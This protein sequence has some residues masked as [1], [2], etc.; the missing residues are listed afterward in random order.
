MRL[1]ARPAALLLAAVVAGCGGGGASAPA[2]TATVAANNGCTNA[3]APF[4]VSCAFTVNAVTI[5][6]SEG[7]P[8][9]DVDF[10][11]NAYSPNISHFGYGPTKIVRMYI[12]LSGMVPIANCSAQPTPTG[13]LSQAMLNA[14]SAGIA[15][16]AGT[17]IRVMPRFVYNYGPI[18]AP[19]APLAV[20][21]THIAQLVPILL[22]NKDLI[23]GMPAGFIGTWG[24]WHDSTNGNVTPA[25]IATVL[26]AELGQLGGVFPIFVR[27]P[28]LLLSYEN[29]SLTPPA[30]LG[31]HDDA[32]ASAADDE[33]T[34]DPGAP[35]NPL[36]VAVA[37][38]Q[39]YQAA[40]STASE[41]IAEFAG[42][43]V[44]DDNCTA[45]DAYAYIYHPQSFTLFPYPADIG[46]ALQTGGCIASFYNKIG[47]RIALQ[48][49][50][51]SG[52]PVAG[53]TLTGTVT[54]VNAGYGRVVRARPATLVLLS[55]G[56][57]LARTAAASIDPRTLASSPSPLP[58]TYPF[59]LTLPATLP[60]GVLTLALYLADP[61][62]S[63]TALPAYALPLNS[64][65]G[66][67]NPVFNPATGNNTLLTFAHQ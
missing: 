22:A 3:S 60:S 36:N 13:P 41:F 39:S 38:L 14:V 2:P 67:G 37:Q 35:L 31:L 44:T 18:G 26:N 7:A 30:N 65:D 11:V 8:Y 19:D 54:L 33:G 5:S 1:T 42:D 58:A 9:G 51:L 34:F 48:S 55:N 63:L 25:A 15:A 32:Y 17:G 10:W 62:T 40:V 12:C 49:A 4:S 16:Y 57:V 64:L 50:T 43:Y 59:T 53:G 29:G 23:F 45:L 20:I 52:N 24:E 21:T 47:T 46:T 66:S 27:Y 61:A 28:G 6:T 56:T